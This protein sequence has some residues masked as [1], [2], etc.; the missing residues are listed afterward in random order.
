[1]RSDQEANIV[2]Q[3][4]IDEQLADTR[5]RFSRTPTRPN[6][7]LSAKFVCSN[8]KF[9]WVATPG[10]QEHYFG[11]DGTVGSCPRCDN[12]YCFPVTE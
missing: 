5:H 8:C 6:K 4:M 1:M 12:L 10:P 11:K 9:V 7:S 2:L 3:C